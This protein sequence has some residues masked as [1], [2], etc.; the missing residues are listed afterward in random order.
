VLVVVA[1]MCRVTTAVMHVIHMVA[2]RYRD[3]SAAL[4]MHMVVAIVGTVARRL[5]FV[6]M[7]VVGAMD[8]PVVDVIH[9]ISVRDS[10]VPAR[11]PV[12][13]GVTTVFLMYRRSHRT[14]SEVGSASPQALIHC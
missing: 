6:E 2:V 1:L 11:L 13:M 5:A 9:M 10:H 12:D 7:S 4:P 3:V 8:M 14:S